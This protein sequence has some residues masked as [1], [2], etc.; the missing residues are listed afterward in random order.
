[1]PTPIPI[2]FNKS[3]NFFISIPPYSLMTLYHRKTSFA[4]AFHCHYKCKDDYK[5]LY[6]TFRIKTDIISSNY[7]ESLKQ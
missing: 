6:F 4:I 5:W 2:F 7:T 1:M 3:L